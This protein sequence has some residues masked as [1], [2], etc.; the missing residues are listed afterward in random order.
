MDLGIDPRIMGSSINIIIGQRLVRLLCPDC[1]TAYQPDD[2]EV[3]LINYVMKSHPYPTSIPTPLVLYRPV[4]CAKC[5][6]TG[7]KGRTGI[8]EGV[9][10]DEAVE[11][12]VLRDP[13][14]HIIAEA[15]KPQKI[16]TMIEDGI[17]KVING[18]TSLKE[19][20]RMIELPYIAAR[21]ANQTTQAPTVVPT[22]TTEASEDDFLSHV[23]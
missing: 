3:L 16:P 4:G 11:E 18:H 15:A 1:K 9:V 10:M 14:E 17:E 20:E 22:A 21:V 6:G 5:A 8:F 19:L 2:K 7:F 13:R 12:A 23:V